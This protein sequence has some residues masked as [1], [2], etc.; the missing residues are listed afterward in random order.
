MLLEQIAKG[1]M[2]PEGFIQKVASTAN[3]RYK[4]FRVKKRDGSART[5]HH[6]ARPLKAIQRWLLAQVVQQFPVHQTA[7][8]YRKGKNI[9]EHASLHLG[10]RFL[11]RMDIEE[12]FP[13]ISEK[14]LLTFLRGG[15][16]GVDRVV[17][18]WSSSDVT[19]FLRLVCRNGRLTIGAPTSPALSNAIMWEVD[20]QLF[21][22]ATDIGATYTRYADDIFFSTS[23]P[24]VLFDTEKQIR[25]IIEKAS[26]P[27][28]LSIN[29]KKTRHSSK[30]G[31]RRVTGVTLTTE[32]KVSLGRE[33][34]R[35][36]RRMLHEYKVLSSAERS[37]LAGLLSYVKSIEPDQLN[38]LVLKYGQTVSKAMTQ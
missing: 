33:M 35:N 9:R 30:K 29:Q 34:K 28:G 19:L 4:E 31:Q 16:P 23:T 25:N 17:R 3:H 13:S 24:N 6:P 38:S 12:F 26:L 37:R 7:Y 5:I 8:A 21:K 14:Q 20:Q 15:R 1:L 27:E 22:L 10:S 2:L 32:G 18:L 11:L 36:I